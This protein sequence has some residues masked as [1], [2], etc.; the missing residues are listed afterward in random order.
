MTTIDPDEFLYTGNQVYITEM[1]ERFCGD[2]G[3]VDPRWQ[4]FFNGLADDA[5]GGLKNKSGA[6]WSPSDATVVGQADLAPLADSMD[7]E[8]AEIGR[9]SCRERV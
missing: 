2:P 4:D 7:R 6:S 9:A 1:F 5:H 8:G 3:S